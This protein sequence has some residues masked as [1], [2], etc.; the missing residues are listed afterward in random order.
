MV[1]Y[2]AEQDDDPHYAYL[3]EFWTH[4]TAK[5]DFLKA[6]DLFGRARR[7][8]QTRAPGVELERRPLKVGHS[9]YRSFSWDEDE[10]VASV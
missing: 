1:A 8:L 3:I 7:R 9:P 5:N 2:F 6:S 10:T 4:K